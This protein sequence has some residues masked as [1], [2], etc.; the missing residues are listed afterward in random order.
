MIG[1]IASLVGAF[2]QALN[3]FVTQISQRGHQYN[4]KQII[5]ATHLAMGI[6]LLIPLLA[7]DYWKYFQ[8]EDIWLLVQ[9][10]VPYIIGQLL[11]IVAIRVSDTS[12]ASPLLVLKVPTLAIVSLILFDKHL[13]IQQ[14]ASMGLIVYLAYSMSTMSGKLDVKPAL[15]I[16][17]ASICYGFSDLG[18]TA[19]TLQLEGVSGLERTIVSVTLNYLFCA[20]CLLPFVPVFKVPLS[21]VYNMKWAAITW[22]IAA[23]LLVTGFAMSGVV[24]ANVAQSTRG[25]WGVFLSYMALKLSANSDK[26]IWYKKIKISCFSVVAVALF[27][28]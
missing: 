2:F 17:G 10:N 7:F 25:V 15:L 22:I 20:V 24:E 14:W 11:L 16:I 18:I 21:G 6:I 27:Y 28:I 3:Y 4:S 13:S 23:V 26:K 8:I 5:I 1:I 12:V 9:A 19:Y